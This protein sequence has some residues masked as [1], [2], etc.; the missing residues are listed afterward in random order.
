LPDAVTLGGAYEEGGASPYS[1]KGS[2]DLLQRVVGLQHQRRR[3]FMLKAEVT[4]YCAQLASA[5]PRH[6]ESELKTLG[7]GMEGESALARY[8]VAD[9]L[10]S[11]YM[12]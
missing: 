3:L 1:S 11:S 5:G 6:C 12:L 4:A 9:D 2:P 8:L 7:D 10:I